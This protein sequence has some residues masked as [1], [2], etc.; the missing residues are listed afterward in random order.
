MENFRFKTKYHNTNVALCEA[1]K[2]GLTMEDKG[3]H[4]QSGF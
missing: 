4:V 3:E 2:V 1:T